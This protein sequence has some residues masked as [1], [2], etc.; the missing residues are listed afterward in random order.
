[1]KKYL[2]S[3]FLLVICISCSSSKNSEVFIE[4][5]EGRYLFN[6]NEVL[7][8]YFKDKELFVK[9]R[10][11]DDIKPLKLN[12]SS[13]YMKALN[14]KIMFV[15]L[16]KMHIELAEKT[17]HKG[18]KYHFRKMIANE[19]TPNEYFEAKNY[20]KALE[21]FLEI[22]KQDS[23][24]PVIREYNINKIGYNYLEGNEIGKAIEVLKINTYL[25]P[26]SSNTYDSLG[27]AYLKAK[28]TTNAVENYTKALSINSENNS[29]LR[30]LKKITK[31]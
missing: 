23:L 10:N 21:T 15:N 19:K 27:D 5:A 18:V 3:L 17:E 11:R 25:Y 2:L 30:M 8:V 6:A 22:K 1:M 16:P 14:E 28:D 31:K 9:W 13:F 4:N 20:K 29:A 24:S 26:K 7:E 12:D